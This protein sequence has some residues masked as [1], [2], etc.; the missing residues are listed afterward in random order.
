MA[1]SGRVGIVACVVPFGV[2]P[3]A[4][5]STGI[6]N[7]SFPSA[8]TGCNGCH[9]GGNTPTSTIWPT[10]A[11]YVEIG[12]TACY[13]IRVT[14]PTGADKMGFN[15]QING[16]QDL[17]TGGSYTTNTKLISNAGKDDVTHS[18]RISYSGS[19]ARGSF[20]WTPTTHGTFTITAW[21][22]AVSNDSDGAADDKA[23]SVTKTVYGCRDND[24]DGYYSSSS[25]SGCPG[26]A[27]CD[28]N[29]DDEYPGNTEICDNK[30][31]D[32]DGSTDEGCDDDNDKLLRRKH[33]DR[34]HAEH[35]H[36]R[37][38]RL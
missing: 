11:S 1:A 27:D 21:G 23:D 12:D 37:R 14:K 30:D 38:R 28:D 18:A 25:P 8:S 2:G 26:T 9:S 34:R 22:N 10:S 35:V 36:I 5:Y 6:H 32:C 31:N 33:D 3:A 16:T 7:D 29:D 19:Y 15:A 4:A 13:Y 17:E 20:C 24:G